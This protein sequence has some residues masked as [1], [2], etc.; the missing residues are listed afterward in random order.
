[1]DKHVSHLRALIATGVL[2]RHA[3]EGMECVTFAR[4]VV[5]VL[6]QLS[7]LSDSYCWHLY[8]KVLLSGQIPV[9][10]VP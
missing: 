8:P 10:T 2:T 6:D 1:M 3:Q 4:W 7:S 9:T 5:G